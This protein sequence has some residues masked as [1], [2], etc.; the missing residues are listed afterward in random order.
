[1]IGLTK[2]DGKMPPDQAFRGCLMLS[3]GLGIM[4]ASIGV[5]ILCLSK[6]GC[7]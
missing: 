7:V 2:Y 6:A 1:M 5:F 4:L 3:A